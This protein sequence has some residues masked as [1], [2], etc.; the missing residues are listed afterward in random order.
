MYCLSIYRQQNDLILWFDQNRK[1]TS[2]SEQYIG[3]IGSA[4]ISSEK[5]CGLWNF[6][7]HKSYL[8][9]WQT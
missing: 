6:T 7:S 2:F 1:G 3:W 8:V 5:D 9:E 4:I